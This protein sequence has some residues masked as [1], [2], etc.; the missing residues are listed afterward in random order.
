MATMPDPGPTAP[1]KLPFTDLVAVGNHQFAVTAIGDGYILD[2][3]A[4]T[5]TQRFC[6]LPGEDGTGTP[7]AIE[8]R[9]DALTFDSATNKLWAQPVT[10]DLAGT[11]I[12]SELA[13]YDRDSGVDLTWTTLDNGTAATAMIVLDGV[14]VFGQGSRLQRQDSELSVDDL[15]RFGIRSIDGIALDPITGA[16]VVVDKVTDTVVDIDRATLDF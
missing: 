13:S 1:L 14:M 15:E 9:T 2:T 5:L 11:F 7:L 12:R 8:Q 16:L 3:Q 4:M 10:R 6:Y